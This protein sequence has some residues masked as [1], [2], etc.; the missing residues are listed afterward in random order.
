MLFVHSVASYAH[1]PS[2]LGLQTPTQYLHLWKSLYQSSD[3]RQAEDD[4]FSSWVFGRLDFLHVQWNHSTSSR[5]MQGSVGEGKGF[6]SSYIVKVHLP[7][8]TH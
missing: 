8:A 6:P 7:L 2:L 1:A 5:P 4:K 3:S